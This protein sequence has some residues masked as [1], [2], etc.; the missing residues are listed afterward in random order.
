MAY[1]HGYSAR[2][3]Q[4]LSNKAAALCGVVHDGLAF[5]P[6]ASFAAAFLCF[7]LEHLGR[8][9][10][11]V[12]RIRDTLVPGSHVVVVEGDQ[13]ACVFHVS[14]MPI[15]EVALVTGFADQAHLTRVFKRVLGVTPGAV[16]SAVR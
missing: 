12:A 7:V 15:A 11:G 6:R 16:A 4:R 3:A 10:E 9:L 1:L 8:P 2:E 14:G 13:G 5:P